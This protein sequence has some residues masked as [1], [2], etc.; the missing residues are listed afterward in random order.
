D[1]IPLRANTLDLAQRNPA[2]FG[3]FRLPPPPPEIADQRAA[4]GG[5]IVY[6]ERTPLQP[7]DGGVRE[8]R[9]S[10]GHCCPV[11][12]R[13]GGPARGAA[14]MSSGFFV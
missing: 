10:V 5:L 6:D 14:G 4:D 7:S 12:P 13:Q 8:M 1:L 11:K 3:F 2:V 9:I